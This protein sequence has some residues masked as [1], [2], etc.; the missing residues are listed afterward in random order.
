MFYFRF[1]LEDS[2]RTVLTLIYET[3][4]AAKHRYSGSEV[5]SSSGPF[6][7]GRQ[8][9]RYIVLVTCPSGGEGR[10][11]LAS[12]STHDSPALLELGCC[13]CRSNCRLEMETAGEV[14]PAQSVI[15]A[16]LKGCS[17]Q[18]EKSKDSVIFMLRLETAFSWEGLAFSIKL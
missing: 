18:R 14:S 1:S 2:Q 6:F 8:C 12:H 5:N 15:E 11:V 10:G 7:S 13:L 16:A 17:H 9:S 3:F 4:P